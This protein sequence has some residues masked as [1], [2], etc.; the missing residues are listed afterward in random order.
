[1]SINSQVLATMKSQ[2]IVDDSGLDGPAN[3]PAS[4]A[5]KVH[6]TA[7][8]GVPETSLTAN[9]R[10]RLLNPATSYSSISGKIENITSME[11]VN[12]S[13]AT[14]NAISFAD[15]EEVAMTFENFKSK[16]RLS[17]FTKIPSQVNLNFTKRYMAEAI[18]LRQEQLG[19]EFENFFGSG[20]RDAKTAFDDHSELYGEVLSQELQEIQNELGFWLNNKKSL[21]AQVLPHK[22]DF[23]NIATVPLTA[24]PEDFTGPGRYEYFVSAMQSLKNITE[25]NI[26]AKALIKAISLKEGFDTYRTAKFTT[27]AQATSVSLLD[28]LQMFHSG[29]LCEFIQAAEA[30]AKSALEALYSLPQDNSVD[31]SDFNQ[32]RDFIVK[33][34]S[35]IED[36]SSQVHYYAELVDLVQTIYV[37]V[38]SAF[39]YLKV[40]K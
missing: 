20:A 4:E 3:A 40:E 37:Y 23:I 32:T 35:E 9:L 15:A 38:S 18:K 29:Y 26:H 36:L 14:K 13:I 39:D 27:G 6:T 16:V 31:I 24:F 28:Y 33:N 11:E 22:G 21:P 2:G 1:M 7:K 19:S 34:G 12:A 10:Q 5:L 25:E 30:S 17:E 8:N